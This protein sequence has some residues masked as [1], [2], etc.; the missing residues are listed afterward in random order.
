MI[1]KKIEKFI[2][3]KLLNNKYFRIVSLNLNDKKIIFDIK[4]INYDNIDIR[5]LK[6][7]LINHH[8]DKLNLNDSYK[9]QLFN[10]L[11]Y[12]DL[13]FH[14]KACLIHFLLNK[15]WDIKNLTT[16]FLSNEDY[17]FLSK[18]NLKIK[19]IKTRK[20]RFNLLLILL[21][22][23][24]RYSRYLIE[25]SYFPEKK[26]NYDKSI[27]YFKMLR[28]WVD[29]AENLFINKLGES[30]DNTIIHVNPGYIREL[31]S[32][33]QEKYLKHL[34]KSKRNYFLYVPKVKLLRIIAMAIKINLMRFPNDLKIP[35]IIV[36][37]ERMA[38][39]NYV[40][41]E[42]LYFFSKTK[43]DVIV[44]TANISSMDL[45]KYNAQYQ[46][47]R[48]VDF[49]LSHDRFLIIDDNVYLIGTSIKDAGKRWFGFSRINDANRILER[50]KDYL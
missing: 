2:R 1:L 41:Y 42:T 20:T 43:V 29:L 35:L 39:D 38:I 15:T 24:S 49:N 48:I 37:F 33:R 36:I 21:I 34:Q 16:S 31:P 3:A 26:S 45:E 5:D 23:I 50:V 27:K 32:K 9:N 8:L 6:I 7:T 22:I 14:K 46:N 10:Y 40:N 12:I 11:F 4:E 47:V 18:L 17:I 30:L 44:F 19:D 25:R 13:N 28:A